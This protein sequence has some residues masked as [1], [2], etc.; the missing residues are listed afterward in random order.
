MPLLTG[1]YNKLE[2]W[3]AEV[4]EANQLLVSLRKL[5]GGPT[6]LVMHPLG[7][8]RVTQR[9][10]PLNL[11][12]DKVGAQKPSDANRFTL[13]ATAGLDAA[14]DASEQFAI[15]Q[16]QNVKDPL[17]APA[18]QPEDGGLMLAAANGGFR[19]GAVAE[20]TVRHET[21]IIDT[22]YRRYLAAVS[23]L[24]S[25]LF[26]L[27]LRGNAV[28]RSPISNRTRKELQPFE[29]TIAI[30][31]DRWAVASARDN[32]AVGGS[33]VFNSEAQAREFLANQVALDA[34]N[35]NGMHVIPESELAGA[36]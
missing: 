1:E 7:R 5:D 2:N 4:P 25:R 27:F 36:L 24:T 12:I 3:V 20:R 23:Q 6:E 17:S 29:N 18:F 13:S 19:T 16:Y 32:R 33:A 34:R 31:K 28:A 15:G 8:L 21:I 22:N 11:T 26:D 14:G 35:E 30:G 10:V 9:A